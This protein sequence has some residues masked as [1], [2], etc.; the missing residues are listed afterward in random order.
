[1]AAPAFAPIPESKTFFLPQFR[2]HNYAAAGA[3]ASISLRKNVEFRNEIHIF[4]PFGQIVR[5]EL[6]QAT[7]DRSLKSTFIGSSSI[8]VHTLIGPLSLSAN[9]YELKE[10]PWSVLVNF[11]YILF[12]KSP[13]D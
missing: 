8:I 3:V 12:N 4:H 1:I 10:K 11:G 6:N 7:Y 5:N 13:R 2:A 9:Y